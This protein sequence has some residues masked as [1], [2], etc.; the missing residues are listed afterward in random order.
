MIISLGRQ[1]LEQRAV[2][3]HTCS[4]CKQRDQA[5]M[6]DSTYGEIAGRGRWLLPWKCGC[7]GENCDE[8]SAR[9]LMVR[10]YSKAKTYNILHHSWFWELVLR[11]EWGE[12][13]DVSPSVYAEAVNVLWREHGRPDPALL[14]QR[15]IR[16][17]REPVTIL[18]LNLVIENYYMRQRLYGVKVTTSLQMALRTF[19]DF[20]PF[21]LFSSGRSLEQST[22][23]TVPGY[24]ITG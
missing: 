10:E 9:I 12:T 11:V 20:K 4:W 18:S 8:E 24:R 16:K 1:L 21:I 15:Y 5:R 6:E 7:L 2:A 17:C 3:A 23:S 22:N 14:L 19:Q 13:P